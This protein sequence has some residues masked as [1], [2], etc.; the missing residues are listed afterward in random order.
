MLAGCTSES[1]KPEEPAQPEKKGPELILARSGFQKVYIAA[2]GWNADARPYRLASV[3]TSDG[4]GHDG[5]WAVWVG[6]FASPTTQR[7]INLPWSGST[8]Q[9]AAAPGFI[10]GSEDSCV[11]SNAYD[12]PS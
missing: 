5:K 4:N 12:K 3:A 8:D 11:R 2:R 1:N 10:R 6:S 9:G 7:V